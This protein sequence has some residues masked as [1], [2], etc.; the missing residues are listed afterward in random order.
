MFGNLINIHDFIMLAEKAKQGRLDK[1]FSK[2]LARKKKRVRQAWNSSAGG[3]GQKSWMNIRAIMERRNFM[4]T[5]DAET[6]FREYIFSKYLSG[7]KSLRALSLGCGAGANELRWAG[8]GP[9]LRIDAYDLSEASIELARE[10]AVER[11]FQDILNF[12]VGD[13]FNLEGREN[14]YDFI[15]CEASLHHFSPLDKVVPRISSFLKE[16]GLFYFHEFVGPARFQWTKRQMEAADAVL[17]ILPSK[18]KVRWGGDLGIKSRVHRPSLLSMLLWDPSEAVESSNILPMVHKLFDICE[19]K[20]FGGAI[21]NLLF[22]DIAHNFL[23]DDE[24]TLDLIDLCIDI[25]TKML[26][27]NAIESDFVVAVCKRKPLDRGESC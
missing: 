9:F 8:F 13:V 6:D 26:K 21:L 27:H 25:E 11:G 3:D 5:G 12:Q 18:Y 20:P 24:E 1:V 7:K 15:I 4:I 10:G 22:Q 19:L 2:L 14:Y 23:S 16:D 17:S